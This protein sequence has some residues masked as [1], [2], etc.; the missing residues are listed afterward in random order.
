MTAIDAIAQTDTL[1]V[2]VDTIY[3]SGYT[4]INIRI[5]EEENW[6][7]NEWEVYLCDKKL[8]TSFRWYP[9]PVLYDFCHHADGSGTPC[10]LRDINN[11]KRGE[12]IV[13]AF[14]GGSGGNEAGFIYTLDTI[15]TEIGVFDGMDGALGPFGLEDIDGDTAMEVIMYD[16]HNNYWPY[17]NG[18]MASICLVWKWDGNKYRLANFK[19]AN[20]ILRNVN[21][22]NP[23]SLSYLLEKIKNNPDKINNF[24]PAI[25][26]NW[27]PELMELMLAFI[28][29]NKTP[30]AE[31]A[32]EY[33]WVEGDTTRKIYE[34]LF[35]DHVKSGPHWDELQK[36][37]W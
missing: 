22:L 33:S 24:N 25:E 36:S 30:L 35:W 34:R 8:M 32:C 9:G 20:Q 17:G 15:A 13:V 5:V 7:E 3:F 37:D 10:Y 26:T 21:H 19:M 23:D 18:S 31:K 29:T 2:P 1:R 12:F 11:D 16:E 14:S 6:W 28:Y 4:A 27:P